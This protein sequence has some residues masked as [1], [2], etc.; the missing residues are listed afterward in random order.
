M[1]FLE[2]LHFLDY[3]KVKTNLKNI[4]TTIIDVKF[5]KEFKS[6]LRIGL[7]SEDNPGNRKSLPNNEEKN[8]EN[9]GKTSATIP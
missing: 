1:Q 2:I 5:E 7:T 3:R 9:R 4:Q 6:E 8:P